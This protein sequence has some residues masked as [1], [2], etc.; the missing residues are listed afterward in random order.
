MKT[1]FEADIRLV[2]RVP[3]S[4]AG[5]TEEERQAAAVHAETIL[6]DKLKQ[7]VAKYGDVVSDVVEEVRER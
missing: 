6:A 2:V 5:E 1:N 4:V 7:A 3:F